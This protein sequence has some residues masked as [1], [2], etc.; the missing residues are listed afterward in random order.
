M[1]RCRDAY[2]FIDDVPVY[3][4]QFRLRG[5]P[6]TKLA[7]RSGVGGPFTIDLCTGYLVVDKVEHGDQS[8]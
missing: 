2:D 7:T 6:C 8:G 3:F 4:G 1:A 5:D